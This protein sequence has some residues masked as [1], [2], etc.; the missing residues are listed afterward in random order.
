MLLFRENSSISAVPNCEVM[1]VSV[2][3]ISCSVSVRHHCCSDGLSR[4]DDPLTRAVMDLSCQELVF[5]N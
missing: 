5:R 3:A 2:I 1:I 4:P